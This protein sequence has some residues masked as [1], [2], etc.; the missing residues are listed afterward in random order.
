MQY[1]VS[2]G[3][4]QH[5]LHAHVEEYMTEITLMLVLCRLCGLAV[6]CEHC[7][8]NRVRMKHCQCRRIT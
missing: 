7:I 5:D 4:D 2:A 8:G 1:W 6:V 3:R